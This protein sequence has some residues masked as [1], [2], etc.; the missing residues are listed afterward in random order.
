M[1]KSVYHAGY[2]ATVLFLMVFGL[3]MGGSVLPLFACGGVSERSLSVSLAEHVANH[4]KH[5]GIRLLGALQL[6]SQ[7]VDGLTPRGLSGLAWDEQAQLLYAVSDRGNLF[8]L[9]PQF[10]D[11]VLVDITFVAAYPLQDA[12]GA[13]LQRPYNDAEGLAMRTR[14]EHNVKASQLLVSFERKARVARY[15]P[16]GEWVGDELLP[17]QLQDTGNY[18]SPNKALEAVTYLYDDENKLLTVPERP[19]QGDSPDEVPIFSLTGK[20]WRYPLFKAA[21]NSAIVAME[22]LADG[23][24]LMLERA[25]VSTQQPLIIT[26]RRTTLTASPKMLLTVQNIAVLDSSQ[27]WRLDNFEGLTHHYDNYFFMVSDDNYRASQKTILVYFELLPSF[28][29]VTP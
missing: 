1:P 15:R 23:S 18:T 26:L 8:H 29:Q 2:S 16:T 3:T 14:A 27:Q 24:L 17:D 25:F 10:N 5:M 4:E 13:P 20:F 21:P 12:V 28:F 7:A 9:R 11:R 6:S 22:T 19:L